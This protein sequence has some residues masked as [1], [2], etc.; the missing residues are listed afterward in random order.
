MPSAPVKRSRRR[1]LGESVYGFL[2]LART[3]LL[4]LGTAALLVAGVWMASGNA[5][6]ALLGSD[7]GTV[8]IASC[9]PD[10]C[11]GRFVPDTGSAPQRVTVAHA[12]SGTP[13]ERLDVAVRDAGERHVVRTDAAGVLY[14]LAPVAGALLLASI[15]VVG[16]LRMRR[17][18]VSMGLLGAAALGATWALLTF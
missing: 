18:G 8:R 9:G 14:S 3:L 6:P 7:T 1:R 12:V 10:E 11:T 17:L 13:G 4:V 15:V 2:L 16:G 5:Y